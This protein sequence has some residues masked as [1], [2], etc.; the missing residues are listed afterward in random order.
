MFQFNILCCQLTGSLPL[1]EEWIYQSKELGSLVDTE[2]FIFHHPDITEEARQRSRDCR[3][4]AQPGL[5]TGI[6]FYLT[7][8]FDSKG[9][10]KSDLTKLI[11]LSGAKIVNRYTSFIIIAGFPSF[12]GTHNIITSLHSKGYLLVS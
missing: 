1:Q 6:H 7:G 8:G 4:R 5:F 12:F 2:L 3:I 11:A 10:S 9:M